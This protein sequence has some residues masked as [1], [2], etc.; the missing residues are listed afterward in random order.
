MAFKR[1]LN[2]PG[3]SFFLF[4]PRGTGKST[5]LRD[6]FCPDLT[7]DLLSTQ[8]FLEM[9]ANPEKLRE[10]VLALPE[11]SKIVIDEVQRNSMLLNEVH[12]LIFEFEDKYQFALTGSSSRKLK[13]ENVNLLAGR[14][15]TRHFFTITSQEA[16]SDFSIENALRFGTLPRVLNLKKNEDKIDYLNSYVETYLREEIQQ[17][18]VVR[19]L[20]SYSRFLNHVAILNGQVMNLSNI[21]REAAIPRAT[22]DGYFSILRDTLLGD[23]VESIHLKAKVKEVSTPKF[24]FF[25]CGV[26]RALRQDLRQPL[27]PEKGFLLENLILNELKAFSSYKGL[28]WQVHYWGVPSGG[29]VDFIVSCHPKKIAIE[30]KATKTWRKSDSQGLKTLLAAGRV[31]RAL[32]VYLGT[33]KLKK[34]G[35]EILPADRFLKSLW[36][37]EVG[38]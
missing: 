13:K 22:L 28:Q 21:S 1:A 11:H 15:I 24:Y 17:E 2:V 3:Q 36:L 4:G 32:G 9:S 8:S 38:N 20:M 12:R 16:G 10:Y 33:E 19:N 31:D 5:W 37:G 6:Q 25:D 7:I 18:A 35:I 29:E 30:I 14:A 23:F 27:G 34:D 26:V